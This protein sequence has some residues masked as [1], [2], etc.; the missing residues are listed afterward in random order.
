MITKLT[1]K[2][3]ASSITL[4]AQFKDWVCEKELAYDHWMDDLDVCYT[5]YINSL[6]VDPKIQK[7][8]E[9]RKTAL[10][11]L[12]PHEREILGFGVKNDSKI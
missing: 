3:A 4:F 12:T 1:P 5:Q 6:I 10:A 11:K 8:E 9:Q 7:L 2:A